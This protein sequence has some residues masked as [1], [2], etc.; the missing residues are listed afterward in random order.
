MPA[1]I[2]VSSSDGQTTTLDLEEES[3]TIGRS[4]GNT[5]SYPDDPRL[6]RRHLAFEREGK[7]WSARDL[8]S[9]NGAFLNQEKLAEPRLLRRGDVIT[10]A[11]LRIVFELE[12]EAD[13]DPADSTGQVVFETSGVEHFEM[14]TQFARLDKIMESGAK[15]AIGKDAKARRWTSPAMALLR[16]G[17][18]LASPRPLEEL[19]DVI[20]VLAMEAAGAARGVL[21]TLDERDELKPRARRGSDFRIS[22]RVRDQVLRERMSL[23]IQD[24]LVDPRWKEQHSIISQGIRSLMAA[25]LQTDDRVIGM[26]YLDS[27]ETSE[28]TT[29]DLELITVMAN[30]AAVRIEHARLAVVERRRELLEKEL[31]Q[32]ADIQMGCIPE[33][34]PLVP[35]YEL[36]GVTSPCRTVG[37]DYY[38]YFT[39]SDGKLVFLIADVAGKGM[40]AA[41]LVM[42]LQARIQALAETADDLGR[43][44]GR[45]NRMIK[46]VCPS[47]RFITCFLALLDPA[48]GLMQWANAGHEPGVVLRRSGRI[49]RLGAGGP[50]LGLFIE[51]THG[52]GMTTMEPGDRLLLVTDGVTEAQSPRGEEFGMS[53]VENLIVEFFN[54]G[55]GDLVEELNRAVHKWTGDGS[56]HDD[57]TVVALRRDDAPTVT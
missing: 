12:A 16:A 30:I 51:I 47:N 27:G 13:P 8:G 56:P 4:S 22:K 31:E 40:P 26:L 9:S 36:A 42:N 17:R 14:T 3:V 37:G 45:L 15:A 50:P 1:R 41:L 2:V 19:F 55:A 32:A 39:R 29:E 18:E 43:T 35:G 5:L 54:R 6:S 28:F 49:E 52:T 25:P 23:I 44:I 11:G 34:A 38:D 20:L 21:L 33:R 7:G 57:V 48:T 53:R 24:A 10:A 46:D